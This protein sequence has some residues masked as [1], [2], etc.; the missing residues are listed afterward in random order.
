MVNAAE[1]LHEHPI[2]ADPMSNTS[3]MGRTEPEAFA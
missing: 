2:M 1:R 3:S